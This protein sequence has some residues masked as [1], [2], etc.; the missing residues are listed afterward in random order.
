MGVMIDSIARWRFGINIVTGWQTAE[1]DQMGMWPGNDYFGYRYECA[2]EYM[3]VMKDLWTQGRSNFNGSISPWKIA[4][5]CHCL[6]LTSSLLLRARAFAAKYCDYNFTSGAGLN[7]PTAFKE[8]NSRLVETSKIEGRN[9]GALLLFTIIADEMDD[10]AHAKFEQYNH[11]TD[12]ETLAW[13]KNQS[14]KTKRLTNSPLLREWLTR[15]Q[16]VMP[17]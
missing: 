10:A 17:T 3:Q 2:T 9:V 12:V 13:M 5:Y 15:S 14:G 6:P 16:S 1:Y 4:D 11:W 8:A 7:Q